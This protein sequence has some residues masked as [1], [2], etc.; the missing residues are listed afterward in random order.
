MSGR[1]SGYKETFAAA[2]LFWLGFLA[3]RI[4]LYRKF[5]ARAGC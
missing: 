1:R 3:V 4:S 2:A 5:P